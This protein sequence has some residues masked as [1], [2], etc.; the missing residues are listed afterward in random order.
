MDISCKKVV[1]VILAGGLGKRMD[2]TMPKV[3]F[4]IGGVPMIV[5]ILQTLTQLA[6]SQVHLEKVIVVVGQYYKVIQS[7]IDQYKDNGMLCP[8]LDIT[9]VMQTPAPLGTGHAIMCCKEELQKYPDTDVLILSGDVPLISSQTMF[10]LVAMDNTVKLI[11]THMSD[12]SG[13]G[14][15]KVNTAN[16]FERIVE[17][18]D[19]SEEELTITQINSGI[20]CIQSTALCNHIHQVQNNNAQGEYYLTDVIEII[21]REIESESESEEENVIGIGIFNIDETRQYEIMGVNTIE[22]LKELERKCI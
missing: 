3:V 17:H 12:P 11:T 8:N 19:C 20:Y 1:A 16:Q 5:R 2:P 6:T 9:Y 15:I 10:Q 22:Q 4:E 13:Y 14:R 7:V 21:K 18:K